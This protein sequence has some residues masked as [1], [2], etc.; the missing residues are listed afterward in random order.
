MVCS[1][2]AASRPNRSRIRATRDRIFIEDTRSEDGSTDRSHFILSVQVDQFL[3]CHALQRREP[4]EAEKKII[5]R[6][7]HERIVEG[8]RD[9]KMR[10]YHPDEVPLGASGSNL[11]LGALV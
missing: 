8:R 6:Q 4:T 2:G 10:F 1:I 9:E 11:T 3:P 5:L 7:L